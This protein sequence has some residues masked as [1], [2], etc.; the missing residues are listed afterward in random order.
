MAFVVKHQQTLKEHSRAP[1][2]RKWK[3]VYKYLVGI[4]VYGIVRIGIGYFSS[5]MWLSL[6]Y[7]GDCSHKPVSAALGDFLTT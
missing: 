3:S 7:G 4:L 5:E 2:S 6:T 1:K